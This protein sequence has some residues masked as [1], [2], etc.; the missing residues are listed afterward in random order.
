MM[1]FAYYIQTQSLDATPVSLP[2]DKDSCSAL[3][4]KQFPIHTTIVDEKGAKSGGEEEEQQQQL[5]QEGE[6]VAARTVRAAV[7]EEVVINE[8]A[9]AYSRSTETASKCSQN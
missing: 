2:S 8:S 1:L 9:T 6:E 7:D 5:L 3:C 4:G